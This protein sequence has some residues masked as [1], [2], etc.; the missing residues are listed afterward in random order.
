MSNHFYL[1]PISNITRNICVAERNKY[2]IG[3]IILCVI[4]CAAQYIH[5]TKLHTWQKICYRILRMILLR[6]GWHMSQPTRPCQIRYKNDCS[7]A[8]ATRVSHKQPIFLCSVDM[9]LA[10]VIGK[11][12]TISLRKLS[13]QTTFHSEH[14]E[15]ALKGIVH[16]VRGGWKCG[17]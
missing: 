13:K 7:A 1:L 11:R 4:E 17:S 3:W 10:N 14:V 8:W 9:T 12:D 16:I 15:C 2:N 5:K 6:Y